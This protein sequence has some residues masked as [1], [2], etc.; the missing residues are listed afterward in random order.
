MEIR[1]AW[2]DH[3][4]YV[5][6]LV[7]VPQRARVW[8]GDVL[9]AESTSC[10][11]VQESPYEG[12]PHVDRLYVPDGDVRWEHLTPSDSRTVCPFK[13]EATYWSVATSLDVVW[14]YRTP[15]DEVA[16][17]AGHVGVYHERLRVEL[18]DEWPD[19]ESSTIFPS[20]GD[21]ADLVRLIDVQPAG[22]GHFIGPT[23]RDVTRNVVEGGQMLA[24]AVVAAAKTVPDQRVTWASMVFSKAAR[25][26]AELD[27]DV[28]V[29]RGGRTFSTLEVKVRQEEQLRSVGVLLLDRGAPDVIRHSAAMPDVPGPADAAH[30]DDFRTSGRE[31]R[32]V[33]EAYHP[34]PDRT[35][36][37]EIHA[38][39]RFREAPDEPYLHSA[40]LAQS[41][42]H[43][44]VAAAMLPHPGFGEA[45]AHA[46]LSTG[47]MTATVAFLEQVDVTGWLLYV[48]PAVYAGN[49]LAQGEGRVFTQDGRLVATYSVQGMV[50]GFERDPSSMGLDWSSAL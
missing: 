49:G 6:D 3:P 26:D 12:T 2:P 18:V 35:G 33:G 24:Q 19:G 14:A 8:A 17:L 10:M 21:A 28:E 30:L 34:D 7:P 40:L 25:F 13:G 45:M 9:L 32:V 22:P 4:G 38:W 11:R 29:L 5:V 1:S 39:C 31:I 47:A 27:L 20:W 43:W 50:R 15:F 36:P 41:T 37:P 16:G 42:T 23:Y 48:N 46:T 44:T